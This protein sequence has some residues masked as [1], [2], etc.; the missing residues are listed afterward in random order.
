MTPDPNPY[1]P[2][3]ARLAPTPPPAKGSPVRAVLLGLLADVALTILLS[4]AFVVIYGAYLALTDRS[5]EEIEKLFTDP[6]DD[7]PMMVTL[8][9]IGG[10]GSA[11]GGYVCSRVA[12]HAEYRLAAA[13]IALSLVTGW[14]LIGQDQSARLTLISSVITIFA[15]TFGAWIGARRNRRTA[16]GR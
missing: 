6:E 2:P 7:S 16:G 4:V 9:A 10:F 13:L 5:A 1:A 8:L 14:A 15:T 11:L 12:R 3:A